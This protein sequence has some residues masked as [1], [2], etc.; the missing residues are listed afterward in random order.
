MSEILDENNM[1]ERLGRYISE[2][3]DLIAGI[4][5]ITKELHIFRYYK[6]C[7]PQ[8][9]DIKYA[10]DKFP[11]I[12]QVAKSKYATDDLY[13][14]ITQNYFIVTTCM[15]STKFLYEFDYVKEDSPVELEEIEDT[16][17][18]RDIGHCFKRSDIV[19]C[20]FKNNIFGAKCNLKFRDNSMFKLLLPKRAGL[21]K[22]MPHHAEYRE[23][24][25][26]GLAKQVE[27]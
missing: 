22:G 25:I 19:K 27:K 16:V 6:N 12:L 7:V 3:E 9:D 5:C 18:L 14:G 11:S 17:L 26:D 10:G 15:D 20:E 13:I 4:H 8:E 21:G 1:R 24:I 23:R 2:G